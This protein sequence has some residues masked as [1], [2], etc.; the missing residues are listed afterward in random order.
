MNIPKYRTKKV[1]KDRLEQADHYRAQVQLP[2]K[3]VWAILYGTI[4]DRS[5]ELAGKLRD[6]L[7][8]LISKKIM[9]SYR[10]L[11]SE[12]DFKWYAR[13]WIRDQVDSELQQMVLVWLRHAYR[14]ML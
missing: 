12:Q 11:L 8:D 10:T 13:Q 4:Y 1:T 6:S 3:L 5:P 14:E 7:A 9:E 2:D